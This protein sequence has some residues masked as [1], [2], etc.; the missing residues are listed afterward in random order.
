VRVADEI[1]SNYQHV[2][3]ELTLVPGRSGVFDVVVEADGGADGDGVAERVYSKQRTGRQAHTGEV[4]EAIEALL[5]KG[6]LRYG[7]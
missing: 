6:T 3:S 4:L 7:T 5:P 1:M 2:V